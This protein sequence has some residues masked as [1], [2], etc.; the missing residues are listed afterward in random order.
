[1]LLLY[2]LIVTLLL[3]ALS[4]LAI[5]FFKNKKLISKE[6]VLLSMS[7]IIFSSILYYSLGQ[8][9]ALSGWFLQGKNH[10]LLMT[11]VERL[12]GIDGIILRLQKKLEEDPSDP[13]GWNILGKLYESKDEHALAE[14][15][16]N[17]A[18]A[19]E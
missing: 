9:K 7:V 19:L 14:E 10:Y 2:I 13:K 1:M 5:P 17:K 16:F 11:E 4:I 6:F 18:K 8:S 15:A 3:S 12:G